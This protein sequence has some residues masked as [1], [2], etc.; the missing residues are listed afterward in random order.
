MNTFH[1]PYPATVSRH[2]PYRS[3]QTNIFHNRMHIPSPE[4]SWNAVYTVRQMF[5]LCIDTCLACTASVHSKA[6][7]RAFDS[8]WM[9][10]VAVGAFFFANVARWFNSDLIGKSMCPTKPN[11]EASDLGRTIKRV[12]FSSSTFSV[13][14]LALN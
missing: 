6:R 9:G 5:Q 11:W 10:A 14:H 3:N 8:V 1:F 4:L 2:R 12:L 7:R 13:F